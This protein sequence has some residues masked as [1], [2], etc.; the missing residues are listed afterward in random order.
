MIQCDLPRTF[1]SM[2]IIMK[3][4]WTSFDYFSDFSRYTPSITTGGVLNI[5]C[6]KPPPQSAKRNQWVLRPT[7][8][9]KDAIEAL[10]YPDSMASLNSVTSFKVY[11]TLPPYLFMVPN[12]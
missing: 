10:P 9:V 3:C 12:L 7:S 11:Y 4:Y 8:D 5:Q 6:I 1:M 2:A